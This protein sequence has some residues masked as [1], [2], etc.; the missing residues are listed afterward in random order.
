MKIDEKLFENIIDNLGKDKKEKPAK[1]EKPH[2]MQNLRNGKL[3]DVNNPRDSLY[4]AEATPEQVG[5]LAERLERN[6]QMTGG[7]GPFSKTDKPVTKPIIKKKQTPINIQPIKINYDNYI[8]LT[9]L[10]KPS[11]ES[12]L[13]E[14]NFQILKKENDRS[15]FNREFGGIKGLI[16]K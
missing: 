6:A 2:Y 16:K 1:K 15:I 9:P 7:K 12:L 11:A 3:E 5:A 8:A 13:R 4:P 14:Q 10:P